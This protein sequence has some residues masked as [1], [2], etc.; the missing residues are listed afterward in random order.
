MPESQNT[1]LPSP[2]PRARAWGLRFEGQPGPWN[3]ITDVPGVWVGHQSLIAGQNLRTGV[4]VI[5]PQEYS[6]SRVPAAGFVLNGNGEVSGLAW[7]D[8]SGWLEGPIG[9]TNTCSLG[10]VRDSLRQWMVTEFST[11]ESPC[12]PGL[13]PVV[14]E[15][16]DG[17]LNE[18]EAQQIQT[19]HVLQALHKASGGPVA[20]GNIGGGTGMVAFGFKAGIGTASRQLSLKQ[21][22]YHLGVL[23][24]AN[25]G[26]REDLLLNGQALGR[27]LSTPLP[28]IQ[29]TPEREGSIIGILATDAPLLPIQLKSLAR[30]MALGMARCGGLASHSSG[31]FFLAFSTACPQLNPAGL[32]NWSCLPRQDLNPLLHAA[33]WA[34]EEAIVNAL[35]AGQTLQGYRGNTVFELPLKE[36]QNCLQNTSF[37]A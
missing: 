31:D 4:S 22:K 28:Q 11:P 27:R 36:V 29:Q 14:G 25:F 35:C 6:L 26:S 8:E 7:I 13:L 34:T 18:I 30:R 3:A 2:R 5:L 9:L 24:Q 1:A 20:E 12:S 17:L 16:W 37:S 21:G 19:E 15:T 32:E 33:A 23:V 10:R